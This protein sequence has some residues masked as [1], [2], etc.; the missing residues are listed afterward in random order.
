[1]AHYEPGLR[2]RFVKNT[3]HFKAGETVEVIEPVGKQLRVQRSNGRE[4]NFSPSRSPSSFE[5]GEARELAVAAGDVLLLRGNF[6]DGS[7]MTGG[8]H[9][10]RS[11]WCEWRDSLAC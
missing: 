8:R 5:V 7:K 1:L 9:W 10:N 3:T 4:L 2:L 11:S 6:R